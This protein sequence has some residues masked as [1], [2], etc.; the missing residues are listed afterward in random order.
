MMRDR[1]SKQIETKRKKLNNLCI[2]ISVT[3]LAIIILVIGCYFAISL[4]IEEVHMM[5][6]VCILIVTFLVVCNVSIITILI[7]DS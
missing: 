1:E 6:G 7:I 4:I 2:G 5:V 3:I